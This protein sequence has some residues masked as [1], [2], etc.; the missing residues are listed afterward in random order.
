MPFPALVKPTLLGALCILLGAFSGQA[1]PPA[2]G[3]CSERPRV[4]Q[5]RLFVDNQRWCVESV[6]D[7]PQIEP[8]AFTALEVA[9]DGTL[10]ATR[11]LTGQVMA[12]RDTDGDGLPDAMTVFADGLTLPN[13]LAYHHGDL[14]VAGGANIYRISTDGAVTRIADDLPSGGGFWTGGLAVGEDDRLYVAIGAPCEN[15]EFDDRQRG[16]ILG[17]ALNG[18]DRQ[19]VATGF[20]QPADLAFYRGQLWTLDS[21]P[22]TA[23]S[24][25]F[26][27]L[28]RVEQGGFYGFPY[29]LGSDAPN[30]PSDEFDCAQSIPPRLLFGTGAN[31]VS[32]AAY[33]YATLP[34]TQDTL[35]V[36]LGGEP[37]QIDF[38]GYKAVMVS[39]DENSQPLGVTLLLP[40]RY[41]S[42]KQAFEPYDGAGYF[43]LHIVTLS[44][45]G[46]G[47]YPQ[48]PLAVAVSP[49]GWIYLS[50]TGGEIVALR[51]AHQLPADPDR[52]PLWTP[53]NPDYQPQNKEA[54]GD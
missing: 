15:C 31:P 45:Q 42:L 29:C 35:I 5:G 1:Q 44:E 30:I 8:L 51:P 48:Q 49:R 10:Y 20:R 17:M 43:S 6:V 12:V 11:P 39:F 41:E 36:A 18:D 21:A 46:W 37:A 32:L 33:P 27:E 54:Q 3:K 47:I 2:P 16:A 28:N 4:I 40:Y 25:A 23:K 50:L 14:Y 7:A 9:P 38:V 22:R 53:M 34:G 13:G 24:G 52:Y 26:D 19:T